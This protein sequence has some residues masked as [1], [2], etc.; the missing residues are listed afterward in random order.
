MLTWVVEVE[1]TA[2]A[3]RKE[4]TSFE[5]PGSMKKKVPVR[6]WTAILW[7]DK[8]KGRKQRDMTNKVYRSILKN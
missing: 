2:R 7:A 4:K 5:G 1:K 6:Q 8:K 3:S